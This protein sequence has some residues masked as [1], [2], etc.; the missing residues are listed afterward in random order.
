MYARL[1]LVFALLVLIL[2]VADA[3]KK[4]PLPDEVLKAHTVLFVV[5]P[6]AHA[7]LTNPPASEVIRNDM[8]T[9]MTKWGRFRLVNTLDADLVIVV[10][11]GHVEAPTFSLPPTD[12]GPLNH[13]NSGAP[14][15]DPMITPRDGGQRTAARL[16]AEEDSFEV[17]RGG[18]QHPLDAP[19][20]WEYKGA[21]VLRGP[22]VEAIERFRKAIEESEKQQKP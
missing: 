5:F 18:A 8:Q 9:A 4:P 20:V 21:G 1:T 17:Y 11:K 10:R 19:A 3:K 16:R 15:P 14:T 12:K 22:K 6:D 2:P 7:P 13:P